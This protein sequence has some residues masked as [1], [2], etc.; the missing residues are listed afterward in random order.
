MAVK[1]TN[2]ATG[3]LAANINS[4]VTSISLAGSAGSKFPTLGA[5][6]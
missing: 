2:N 6:D 4:S 3:L 1:L 5:S